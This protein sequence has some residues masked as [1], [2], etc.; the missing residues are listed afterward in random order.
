MDEWLVYSI[1]SCFFKSLWAIF[2]KL[3]SRTIDSTTSNLMQLLVRIIVTLVLAWRRKIP[4]ST[5]SLSALVNHI[6]ELSLYGTI[7][8]VIASTTSVL[9]TFYLSDA[10]RKGNASSVTVI[11]GSYPAIS[12][13]FSICLGLEA[14]NSMKLLGVVLAIG[15]CYCFANS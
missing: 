4:G 10:L 3:A 7:N 2:L 5:L 13:V 14:I 11:T 9:S 12:Y 1:A 6:G 15:S 8:T